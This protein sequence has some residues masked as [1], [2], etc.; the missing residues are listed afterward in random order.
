MVPQPVGGM[1]DYG[2]RNQV[3]RHLNNC[4]NLLIDP[5]YFTLDWVVT[6]GTK[7]IGGRSGSAN[8]GG[9]AGI[10]R[11]ILE[12]VCSNVSKRDNRVPDITESVLNRLDLAIRTGDQFVINGHAEPIGE[13]LEGINPIVRN[14][15][16]KLSERIGSISDIDN[17][18][19]VGGSA[20]MYEKA[21][22]EMFRGS[23]VRVAKDAIFSNV[24]GFQLMGNVALKRSQSSELANA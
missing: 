23:D 17:I 20:H 14:A 2:V 22:C 7:M 19:I 16:E 9:M 5:G 18:I 6:H 24:R 3:L 10:L 8:N 13:Y 15:L 1:Y 12:K 4:N 21:V 11:N